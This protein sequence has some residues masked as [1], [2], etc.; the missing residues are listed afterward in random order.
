MTR[1]IK[2]IL[3]VTGVTGLL[4]AAPSALAGATGVGF[5][6]YGPSLGATA[7]PTLGGASLLLLAG[8]MAIVAVRILRAHTG[9]GSA[10]LVA[11]ALTTA[12]AAGGSG[13]KLVSD[14]QAVPN[15]S[16]EN[17]GGGTVV[18]PGEGS[19]DIA[20]NSSVPQFILNL[21]AGTGCDFT[22]GDGN[23]GLGL[24]NDDPS[25]E[26]GVG[27]FCAVFVSCFLSPQGGSSQ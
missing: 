6:T 4:A 2:R 9:P 14:A 10:W 17:D 16:M 19:W 27:Q 13:I 25:T 7:V 23:G 3:G 1:I 20:N 5:V 12:L 11:A 8:L 15:P 18:I 24:C 21:N 26:V 22:T